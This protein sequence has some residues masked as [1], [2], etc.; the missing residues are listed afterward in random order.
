MS[1][2][3][4]WKLEAK[5]KS[6]YTF[7]GFDLTRLGD[8]SIGYILKQPTSVFRDWVEMPGRYHLDQNYPN[9]FN[10]ATSIQFKLPVAQLV[11]IKIYNMAG[12]EVMTLLDEYRNAG[13]HRIPFQA[14]GM[15]SGVY[16]IRLK[17]GTFSASRRMVLMK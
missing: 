4:Y 11:T 14:D 6:G 1:V 2:Y 10:P 5:L 15:A 8:F 12:R 3:R 16:L 7:H 9:P 17:A 13:V